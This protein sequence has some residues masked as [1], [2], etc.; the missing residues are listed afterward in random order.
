MDVPVA[1]LQLLSKT[2]PPALGGVTVT[3][4]LPLR[5]SLVAVIVAGPT[6][7]PLTSP[8]ALTPAI[9]GLLEL[10]VTTRPDSR[11]PPASRRVVVNCWTDPT[12]TLALAG[13]SVTVA[14]GAVK[15]AVVPLAMLDKPPNTALESSVPR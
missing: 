11:L 5:P 15:L 1:V 7:S 6:T 3:V 14:T 8:I 9:V 13:L 10:H 2:T 4:A 12:A